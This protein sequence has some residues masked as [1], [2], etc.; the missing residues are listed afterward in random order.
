MT[1]TTKAMATLALSLLAAAQV[2]SS[3]V[4]WVTPGFSGTTALSSRTGLHAQLNP[5]I[6]TILPS[7][8]VE[9]FS[10]VKELES[11]GQQVTSLCVGEP[12]FAPPQAI[13]QAAAQACL[14]GDTKYTAVTGTVPL[15]RAI[16]NDL[17][18][19]KGLTYNPTTEIVVANGAKQAVYQGILATV[20]TGDAVLIPAPYWPSYPE[21][22]RLAG[23][24]PIIVPTRA[25]DGF[26]LTPD[27]LRAALDLH[28]NI[29]LLIFCNPSNPTGGVH[30][31]TRLQELAAVLQDFPHVLVLS[32]EIYERLCYT[33]YDCPSMASYLYDRTLV[34]NGFSKA[35]A[36]TGFRLGY[37]AAPAPYAKACTTLQ[38]QF[39]SCAGSIS[40]AAGLAALELVDEAELQEKFL[41]M[42]TKRDYVLDRL[43]QLPHVLVAVPPQ[44]AFYVLPD[45][46]H[47][48]TED[49]AFDDV[50]FCKTL[51]Q[52][53]QL[54]IVP[55]SAFGAP[56]TVRISYATS[57]TELAIAMDKLQMFLEELAA[58]TLT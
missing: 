41:E 20:G 45:L 30:D 15:R 6:A 28:P 13:L 31:A 47:Y 57:L 1:R 54:A 51:L 10:L 9:I 11:Q 4:A 50:E 29:K 37:L 19:R 27:A 8:T 16:S 22:V 17:Q 36:M 7:K 25:E 33:G 35:Y 52:R 21:M 46:S 48:M 40:Q 23:A 38:S 44:G 34:I 12:D 14:D 18:T 49:D 2:P 26:L 24:E 56:G 3:A 32:D 55:G 53:H 5:L 43:A 58:A 42:R 39:T